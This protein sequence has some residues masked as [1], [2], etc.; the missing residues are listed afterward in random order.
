MLIEEKPSRIWT[1][2]AAAVVIAACFWSLGSYALIEPDEGRY[3][4]IP[5]EMN[6]SG[7]FITPKL[8]Y[9]K[10]YEKP[11]LLY[12]MTA[13][14]FKIFG[15]N[16]LAARIPIAI[17]AILCAAVV[18]VFAAFLYGRRAGAIS[19]MITATSLLFFG[20]G[21]IILTDMP[22]TLFITLSAASYYAAARTPKGGR[23]T[24]L[25]CVFY[26]STA[27]GVLTKGLVAIVLPGGIITLH[28]ILTRDARFFLA[29]FSLPGIAL[30]FAIT[31]PYFWTI[32]SR[33][34]EFFHFF[35]IREHFL[36]YTTQIHSRYEPFWFFLPL[37]P[38]GLLPWTG[39]I[40]SLFGR[41][42][43]ARDG[44]SSLYLFLWCGVI[45]AFF[46]LSS[47]KLIPYI[48]PCVMPLA[49]AI[50]ATLD[51]SIEERRWMGRGLAVT[52]AISVLF[53]IA[54][55]V[56]AAQGRYIDPSEV[57]PT[58]IIASA[59]LLIGPIASIVLTSRG[60]RY[61]AAVV[62]L[63]ASA[64]IFLCSLASIF[65]I[66]G[67]TRSMKQA[68]MILNERAPDHTPVAWDEVLQGVP[69]YTGKRVIIVGGMGEL[70]FGAER[71]RVETPNAES[72]FW[73]K[74][75][76]ADEWASDRPLAL[77][78]RTENVREILNGARA[79]E[80]IDTGKYS[81]VLN[82]MRGDQ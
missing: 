55:V 41:G 45:L 54:L 69:F 7:D 53:S 60:R 14:S 58:A 67:E 24:A 6:E 77:V 35:F 16:E 34:P 50:G 52:T 71:E 80:T 75:R 4:E 73:T 28:A 40:A 62:V 10:Y 79:A 1:V 43:A 48:T 82:V 12:W 31:V 22:L 47:S 59:A 17:S 39:W 32:C 44:E 68:S 63:C 72:F 61:G 37:L 38:A 30:F 57:M 65:D 66:M 21:H 26:A 9:V 76:F 27:F 74:E 19:S 49:I 2:F 3:A 13:A 64:A 11:P 46:S 51:R 70:E 29:A 33:D 8:N 42:S 20:V 78:V 25:L 56:F 23:R 15:E 5:R 18:G 36:R 81:I